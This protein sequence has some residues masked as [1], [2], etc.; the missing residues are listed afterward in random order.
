VADLAGLDLR[1]DLMIL[2]VFSD[3]NDSIGHWQENDQ[4]QLWQRKKKPLGTTSGI[5][6]GMHSFVVRLPLPAWAA[7]HQRAV[8][9]CWSFEVIKL[10]PLALFL[11]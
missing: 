9:T 7:W 11:A 10:L 6:L 8:V 4:M 1:L 2:K 3:L 5:W